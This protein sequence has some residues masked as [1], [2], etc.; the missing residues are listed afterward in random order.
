MKKNLLDTELVVVS[1]D[2][3]EGLWYNFCNRE[4]T[5]AIKNWELK[6]VRIIFHNVI[7]FVDW[8]RCL[9]CISKLCINTEK[10]NLFNKVINRFYG[11]PIEEIT[12]AIEHKRYQFVSAQGEPSIE[13]VSTGLD[14][15][16]YSPNEFDELKI[17]GELWTTN[18][19]SSA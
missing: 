18:S 11:R 1:L 15:R 19:K 17:K 5:L 8:E 16:I 4:I 3:A 12:D 14:Y 10:T 7:L 13:I 6:V 9:S 2:D